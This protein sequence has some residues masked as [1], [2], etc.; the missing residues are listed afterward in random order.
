MRKPFTLL[1]DKDLDLCLP[2]GKRLSDKKVAS[3]E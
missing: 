1:F 3:R 2:F